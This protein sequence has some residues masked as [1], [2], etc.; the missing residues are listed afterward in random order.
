M[1]LKEETDPSFDDDDDEEEDKAP[2][3][4]PAVIS[5]YPEEDP[6]DSDLY[7]IEGY[8]VD[9]E[10]ISLDFCEKLLL[11]GRYRQ[12]GVMAYTIYKTHQKGEYV[13]AFPV[14]EEERDANVVS[15]AVWIQCKFK[16][17]GLTTIEEDVAVL[18]E[19]GFLEAKRGG[20]RRF[21]RRRK[22]REE[23]EEE[24]EEKE[25][26]K[27][28]R[29]AHDEVGIEFNN[30]SER[31]VL[32]K[33]PRV[34]RLLWAKLK[35]EE[36]ADAPPDLT[37]AEQS[38]RRRKEYLDAGDLETRRRNRGEEQVEEVERV[39][40][41][42]VLSYDEEGRKVD[43]D[44]DDDDEKEE[45]EEE[46]EEEENVDVCGGERESKKVPVTD[47]ASWLYAVE[48]LARER[49]APEYAQE[50]IEKRYERGGCSREAY[51]CISRDIGDVI[52]PKIVNVRVSYNGGN[53]K[54]EQIVT[55]KSD[56]KKIMRRVQTDKKPTPKDVYYLHEEEERKKKKEKKTT[57]NKETAKQEPS[58]QTRSKPSRLTTPP[59]SSFYE[60]IKAEVN[61]SSA[62]LPIKIASGV[63]ILGVGYSI[64]TETYRLFRRVG[65]K[66]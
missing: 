64:L 18:C 4:L 41:K 19:D 59:S 15:M 8:P 45:E 7:E 1:I 11:V 28:E 9:E 22:R 27:R 20:R 16:T 29:A 6:N 3:P 54:T 50:W 44:E 49:S 32:D 35:W 61:Y 60:M 63:A 42:Y 30:E 53:V 66:R 46:E 21:G 51:E 39:L 36:D 24:E 58:T 10:P 23:E 2:S 25:A 37:L 5:N 52:E 33:C 34:L 57:G 12:S 65:G 55:R 17:T 62:G 13:S 31:M 56:G 47:Q 38:E 14:R 43:F 48:I 40:L 26:R